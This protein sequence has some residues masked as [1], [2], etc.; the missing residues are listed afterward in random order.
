MQARRPTALQAGGPRFEPA[1]AHHRFQQPG[2][3]V[4]LNQGSLAGPILSMTVD[5][6]RQQDGRVPQLIAPSLSLDAS[7][8]A[9]SPVRVTQVVPRYARYSESQ[10]RGFH[11]A[12]HP[13]GL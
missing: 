8:P 5:L 9:P 11:V 13:Q 6:E 4:P 12:G 10:A 1:T 2:V 7:Q 3:P